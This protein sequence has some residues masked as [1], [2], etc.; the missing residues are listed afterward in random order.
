MA[1]KVKKK[2]D[3]K[4]N[5]DK[6]QYGSII[7]GVGLLIALFTAFF[8]LEQT[9]LKIVAVTL[10]LFG[11][12]IGFINITEKETNTFLLAGAILVLLLQPFLTSIVQTL[13][14]GSYAS[15]LR[16]LGNIYLNLITLIVPATI[17]VALKAVFKSAKD[18][19]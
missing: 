15:V 4:V 13:G 8:T 1:K 14:L 19:N 9:A 12:I 17:I 11:L 6:F 18:E 7:F 5:L 16:I 2:V 10:I 3:K